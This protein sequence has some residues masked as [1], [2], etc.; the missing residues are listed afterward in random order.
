MHPGTVFLLHGRIKRLERVVGIKYHNIGDAF[1]GGSEQV[2]APRRQRRD[3][4]LGLG[5]G[6][7]G[8]GLAH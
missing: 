7:V 1:V 2:D 5:A 4:G 3:L 8:R 6:V